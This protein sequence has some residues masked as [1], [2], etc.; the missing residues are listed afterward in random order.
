MKREAVTQRDEKVLPS[1]HGLLLDFLL[2]SWRGISRK[3]FIMLE[4][5]FLTGFY[6][7]AKLKQP[8]FVL[9]SAV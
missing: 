4:S 5:L 2:Q 7:K 6:L 8:R 9:F 3:H 1:L